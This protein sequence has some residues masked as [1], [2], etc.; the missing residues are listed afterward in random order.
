MIWRFR[1][2]SV[3]GWRA[4]WLCGVLLL[5]M[6]LGGCRDAKK[7][8]GT[9]LFVTIDFPPTL[10]IDQLVV[11]GS[12]DGT[13]IGPY[14]LPEQPERLLSNGETFRILVPSAANSVPAEVTV[15]GLRESSRVALGTGSVETR[16]GYEVELTVRLEP[17]SPPDTTFCVDCPTGCCMNGYCAVSTFQTCGTGG[18]SCTACNPATADAC[19]PDGFCA[20][21]SAPACNPVNADRCD[22]GRCRCGNRDACGPGLECVSGQCVCSPASCSGCCDGN[23][24]VAGNQRDR[25]G[26]NGATCKNCV[27]QQCKAGGVCG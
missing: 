26:T 19:S 23:T 2:A 14:V 25:C 7:A 17:A 8:S 10:F 1:N 3:A 27:F 5:G 22:K 24:C 18:I 6:L 21:G 13:G 11:S 9:A 16:K 20:C 15:E 12:V 4:P